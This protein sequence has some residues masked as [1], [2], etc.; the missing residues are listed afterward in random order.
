MWKKS[1]KSEK[2]VSLRLFFSVKEARYQFP[3]GKKSCLVY[4]NLSNELQF[5]PINALKKKAQ[6]RKVEQV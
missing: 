2:W 5:S 4:S 1:K 6:S 3:G